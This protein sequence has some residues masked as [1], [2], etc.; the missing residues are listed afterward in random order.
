MNWLAILWNMPLT[1]KVLGLVLLV[2]S[3]FSWAIII[4][5]YRS[6]NQVATKREQFDRAFWS[7]LNLQDYYES[8]SQKSEKDPIEEIF[9]IGYRTLFDMTQAQQQSFAERLDQCKSV[10]SIAQKKWE[11]HHHNRLTW[12]ATIA[13]ISPY[14]GL[15]GTVF[16][17]M[18]VFQGLVATQA[19][20]TALSAV[21]PGISEALGMTA[22]G[23]VV[24]IP[25]TMAYNRLML[26]LEDMVCHYQLF[27]EEFLVLV[28]K[29]SAN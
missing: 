21:A 18:H 29:H 28:R 12:L 4:N 20:N 25:A 22:L 15:L 26:W 23:L 3:L 8:I 9:T 27:Q 5:Q 13:S 24:A 16:G 11:M 14:I 1:V 19:N 2:M 10:M 17:V 7:G 6:L